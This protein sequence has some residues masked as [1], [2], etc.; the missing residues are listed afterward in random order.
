MMDEIA[1]PDVK[2]LDRNEVEGVLRAMRQLRYQA[3]PDMPKRKTGGFQKRSLAELAMAAQAQPQDKAEN[4]AESGTQSGDTTMTAGASDAVPAD[5]E[6][7]MP[8]IVMSRKRWPTMPCRQRKRHQP[9][10]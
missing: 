4:L 9:R 10:K 3:N 1:T 6:I 5:A 8:A 7:N 2:P